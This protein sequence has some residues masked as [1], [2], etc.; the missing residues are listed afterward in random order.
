[1]TSS[2]ITRFLET[3][4]VPRD[5]GHRFSKYRILTDLDLLEDIAVEL[6]KKVDPKTE[7]ICALAMSGIPL[8]VAIA[9]EMKLPLVFYTRDVWDADPDIGLQK[10]LARIP[11]QTRVSMVD[12]H[13]NSGATTSLCHRYLRDEFDADVL[14][15]I[16]PFDFENRTDSI[17]GIEYLSLG[18]ASEFADVLSGL[19][20]AHDFDEVKSRYIGLGSSFW[21]SPSARRQFDSGKVKKAKR[22]WGIP[23]H[24]PRAD[25][26]G[27]D[28]SKQMRRNVPLDHLGIW[29]YFMQPG[30]MSAT[31]GDIACRVDFTDFSG[32]IG[33]EPMGSALAVYMALETGFRGR[34]HFF[35][36]QFGLVPELPSMKSEVFALTQLRLE[37]GRYAV[38]ALETV[39]KLGGEVTTLIVGRTKYGRWPLQ[40]GELSLRKLADEKI[41][42]FTM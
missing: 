29:S 36:N 7:C 21:N 42:V 23:G 41:R 15:V 28:A 8:G 4:I 16:S 18:S 19:F 5:E 14:Q 40:F 34:I 25:S 32:L 20:G 33:L 6:S 10:V 13:I 11:Q 35:D 3:L 39:R 12:T 37:T 9:R 31:V 26:S 24:L 30:L 2:A 17:N 1:M 38:E 27:S 22:L